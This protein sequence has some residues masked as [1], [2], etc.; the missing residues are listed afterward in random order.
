MALQRGPVVYCLEEV[1]NGSDLHDLVLPRTA[2]LSARFNPKLLGG[3]TV[4]TG[5]A[6]RRDMSTWKGALYRS[7]RT[8]LK[9][10]PITAV[11]YAVWANRK[12]G[13]MIVWVR[14][15]G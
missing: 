13:E 3:V 9:S 10:V 1:D 11:P 4:I 7:T 12:P 14:G 6:Q 8:P 5:T 2:R 15:E